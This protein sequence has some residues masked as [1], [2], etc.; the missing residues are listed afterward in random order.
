MGGR[1]CFLLFAPAVEP[2]TRE[3][4]GVGVFAFDAA[5]REEFF[6]LIYILGGGAFVLFAVILL[7]GRFSRDP[8]VGYAIAFLFAGTGVFVAY[9]LFEAL[10]LSLT[11]QGEFSLEIWRSVFQSSQYLS[12]LWGS[13][14]LGAWTATL[15]TV[16]GFLFAFVLGRTNV[17]GK[18]FFTAMATLPVISPPFSLAFAKAAMVTSL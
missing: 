10:R 6:R 12:A 18:K 17:R 15:S 9:P 5:P 13:I 16:L 2:R 4:L 11:S 14:R 7:V 8:L 3:I 1:R